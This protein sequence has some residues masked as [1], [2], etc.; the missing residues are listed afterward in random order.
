MGY[1]VNVNGNR[2]YLILEEDTAKNRING[3]KE[4]I[5]KSKHLSKILFAVVNEY[6][7][8]DLETINHIRQHFNT[9]L[10]HK[11]FMREHALFY[12]RIVHL[13]SVR[14]V[15]TDREKIFT[16]V[17]SY[18]EEIDLDKYYKNMPGKEWS[19]YTLN[20]L[21]NLLGELE[22]DL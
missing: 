20:A 10:E 8:D 9:E 4:A 14:D 7:P 11:Q 1:N 16:D 3:V 21:E 6:D 12:Q 2:V 5:E 15:N 17:G 18:P 22:A 13:V 19:V